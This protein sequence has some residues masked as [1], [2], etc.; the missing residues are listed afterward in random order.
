[1]KKYA[2]Q[3]AQLKSAYSDA[4]SKYATMVNAAK[5]LQTEIAK[6]TQEIKFRDLA[7]KRLEAQMKSNSQTFTDSTQVLETM[8]NDKAQQ[9]TSLR[10][11]LSNLQKA[12]SELTQLNAEIEARSVAVQRH[13]QTIQES[14][15]AKIN[16]AMLTVAAA[17]IAGAIKTNK[18]RAAKER[19]TAT[20]ASEKQKADS[21]R[22]ELQQK[23]QA[24]A[25]GLIKQ[26][27]QLQHGQL[28]LRQ[29]H[30]TAAANSNQAQAS[31]QAQLAN[32]NRRFKAETIRYANALANV[33]M[34]EAEK[35]SNQ[36]E[37]QRLE[38]KMK[39]ITG[40]H[41]ESEI[42]ESTQREQIQ[43][44]QIK[45]GEVQ[46]NKAAVDQELVLQ[47]TPNH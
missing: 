26:I 34:L 8:L 14:S 16:D 29:E 27:E 11:Q 33:Q 4:E 7:I 20:I 42:K 41:S 6:Q 13:I 28:T 32:A 25:S 37:I 22:Q 12:T 46:K 38:E 31:L 47:C 24:E 15:E 39:A 21:D 18:H 1:M 2:I 30:Q 5:S 40:I 19:L 3:N 36:L 35:L 9:E 23:S 44:L 10:Q 17:R 43:A 45:L